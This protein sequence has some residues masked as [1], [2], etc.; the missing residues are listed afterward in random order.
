MKTEMR[1]G[2]E[3]FSDTILFINKTY[4]LSFMCEICYKDEHRG[5]EIIAD[6]REQ[7]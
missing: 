7:T 6:R 5:K 2:G 4:S 3:L 1:R